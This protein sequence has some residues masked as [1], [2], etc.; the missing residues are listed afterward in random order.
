MPESR[1]TTKPASPWVRLRSVRQQVFIYQKMLG[2][3]SPDAKAG[4]CVRVLDRSGAVVGS[5][6][7]NPASKI[8]LR[9]LRFDDGPLDE[10]FWR[11]RITRAADLRR[12]L[13]R[14][15][16]VSDAY[17]LVHAE[18]DGLSGL[19]ADR[20]GDVLSIEVFSRG[21][22]PRLDTLLPL[23]HAAAGTRQHRVTMDANVQKMERFRA[24]PI[25]SPELPTSLRI[26]EHGVRFHVDLRSG[27]K[28]GFFCDQRENRLRLAG[29]C[30]DADVLDVCCYTGGF[31]IYAKKLGGA[32]EVTCVDLDET[33]IAVAR[34]NANLN[35]V[36]VQTVH[37]DAFPYLRQM[38]Q[39]ERTYDVVVLDP[40]KLVFGRKDDG[41]GRDKYFDLNCLA[42][43][44]VRSGGLLLTCSCSG[45]LDGDAF[46][47]IVLRALHRAGRTA[48]IIART[49]AAAD[50]PVATRCPETEYLKALWLR[51]D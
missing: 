35:Q 41:D 38:R 48:Q 34:Q 23:L 36:R 32:R 28:T 42:A 29:M 33:A 49:G 22:W 39:N 25:A 16:D 12:R 40:P 46:A 2:E 30:R 51:L 10:A 8:A 9:M 20:L 13:L 43:P 45:A 7:Y 31:G 47:E 15:D 5:G 11:Q 21:I 18:G 37:A 19:I 17:R 24:E 27:H 3:A 4:D 50:H 1:P 6:I 14:L 44:L 26:R